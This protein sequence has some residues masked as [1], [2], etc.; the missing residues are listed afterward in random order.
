MELKFSRLCRFLPSNNSDRLSKC[1]NDDHPYHRVVYLLLDPDASELMWL[2]LDQSPITE[3]DVD[4]LYTLTSLGDVDPTDSL[5]TSLR[6]DQSSY[7]FIVTLSV[8]RRTVH[9]TPRALN[10]FSCG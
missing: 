3:D 9:C 6:L 5:Q 4:F 7:W 2:G 8:L 1:R 10:D